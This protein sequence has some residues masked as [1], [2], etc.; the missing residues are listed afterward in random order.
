M[1]HDTMQISLR[2]LALI[3][4]TLLTALGVARAQQGSRAMELVGKEPLYYDLSFKYGLIHAKAGYGRLSFTPIKH[5]GRVP[6]YRM[7]LISHSTGFI[8]KVFKL[9]DTLSCA[10]NERLEPLWYEKRAHEGKDDTWERLDYR[11]HGDGSVSIAAKRIKNGELRYDKTL[12]TRGL[13]YDM[14]SIVYY[15]RTFDF[16]SM[17]V[18]VGRQVTFISGAKEVKMDV[19]LRGRQRV[20]DALKREHDCYKLTLAILDPAF[21]NPREAMTVY[22]TTDGRAVPIRMDTKLKIGSARA[23]LRDAGGMLD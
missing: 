7:D 21:T 17:R 5:E 13:T 16:A 6:A 19:I 20:V 2:H 14:M 9:D 12:K 15:V 23:I 18:G 4:L 10:I 22:L 1:R 3:A 8:R 11:Y